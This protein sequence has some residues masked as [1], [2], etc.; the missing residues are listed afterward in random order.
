MPAKERTLEAFRMLF[1]ACFYL[2]K[3][4]SRLVKNKTRL[5]SPA[6]RGGRERRDGDKR[7]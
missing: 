4:F 5:S 2:E 7:A 1:E 6:N 3:I